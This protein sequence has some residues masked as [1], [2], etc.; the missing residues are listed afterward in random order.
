MYI[1]KYIYIYI[2]IKIDSEPV[3]HKEL[4]KTKIKSHVDKVTDFCD[5]KFPCVGSNH[6]CLPVINLDSA[7]KKDIS[8]YSEVFLKEC[9]YIQKKSG[10][11][12]LI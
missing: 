4:L 3:Y 5:K 6:T 7:L 2:Y 12:I 8:Y 11:F 10:I 9:K 1:Y